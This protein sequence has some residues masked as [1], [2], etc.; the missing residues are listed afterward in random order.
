MFTLR[1]NRESG[2]KTRVKIR[3][4][5]RTSEKTRLQSLERLCPEH[6]RSSASFSWGQQELGTSVVNLHLYRTHA[7][8]HPPPPHTHTHTH[9]SHK[10]VTLTKACVRTH[11]HKHTTRQR[12]LPSN[13]THAFLRA[14]IQRE[15]ERGG[16]EARAHY[17]QTWVLAR[18]FHQCSLFI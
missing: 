5:Q 17:T 2:G 3:R 11:A 14:R 9:L 7:R 10:V 6:F 12:E 15:R 1:R 8:A 4:S 13:L 16:G 18:A